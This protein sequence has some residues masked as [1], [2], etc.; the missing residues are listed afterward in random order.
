MN[1]RF[2][3]DS[4][5]P[6]EYK[7]MSQNAREHGSEIWGSTTNPSLIAKK[8]TG[9][10]FT[11]QEALQ[12]QKKIVFEI[13]SIV[14]GA[15]SAE[16]YTDE[17][18]TAEE[19]IGQGKDIATWSDRIVVKI[20]TTLEAFKARTELRKA[21]A[22][23]NNTLV[24]SQEQ[25]F[26]ICLH[27]KL[28]QKDYG[29]IKTEYPQ[30]IS[31]FVGRLD[32]IGQDGMAFV[33]NSMKMKQEHKF[34]L[35]MLEASIRRPEHIKRGIDAG[36][37]IMTSPAKAFQEWFALSKQQQD[38]INATAYAEKLTKLPYWQP[39]DELLSIANLAEF[40]DALESG[41]LDIKHELTD[42]G[43]IRFAQDWKTIIQA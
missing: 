15:V 31:P 17:N 22:A 27:E 35:W 30:F 5:D 13:L 29:P 7:A 40:M 39:P 37:E 9:Q 10:K 12:L 14:P 26:A 28:V 21:G 18:T 25:V 1:T 4:G 23:I 42:K 24:F 20:P 8:L 33:E 32:D 34:G 2:L 36:V 3:L 6:D 41:V 19:M 11:Q 38:A 43:L 16:V